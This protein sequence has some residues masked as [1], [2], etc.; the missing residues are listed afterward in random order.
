[1]CPLLALQP[2]AR[3]LQSVVSRQTSPREVVAGHVQSTLEAVVV[4]EPASVAR[5]TV[6]TFPVVVA[7]VRSEHLTVVLAIQ[8]A[9]CV[10]AGATVV[11]GHLEPV[12]VCLRLHSEHAVLGVVSAPG[13]TLL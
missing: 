2:H 7:V 9:E 12:V 11:P 8:L 6:A 5:R 3:L 1:M 4:P 10:V 13:A